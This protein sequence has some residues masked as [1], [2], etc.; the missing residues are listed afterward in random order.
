MSENEAQILAALQGRKSP[1]GMLVDTFERSL[2]PKCRVTIPSEWRM[3]LHL[4]IEKDKDNAYVYLMPDPREEC[5]MLLPKEAMENLLASRQ[6]ANPFGSDAFDD[7]DEISRA[8]AEFAR[9]VQIAPLDVQNRIRISEKLLR[10]AGIAPE[11]KGRPAEIVLEGAVTKARIWAKGKAPKS[12]AFDR[13][14]WRLAAAAATS[15][16]RGG[17]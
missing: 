6:E 12:D 15:K 14:A 10:S 4:D 17:C 7:D 13:A 1:C 8:E 2:D 11:E 5:I 16:K 9:R 3:A